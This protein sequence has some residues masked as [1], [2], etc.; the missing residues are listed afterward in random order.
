MAIRTYKGG[1]MKAQ[2]QKMEEELPKPVSKKKKANEVLVLE[3]LPEFPISSKHSDII[4][5]PLWNDE[6]TKVQGII[7]EA[8]KEGKPKSGMQRW[9]VQFSI[10]DPKMLAAFKKMKLFKDRF[11]KVK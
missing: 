5:K 2:I 9:R 3:A 10:S 6:H 7:L 1:K 8:K 4:G 11:V